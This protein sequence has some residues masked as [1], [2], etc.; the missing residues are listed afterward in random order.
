[1]RFHPQLLDALQQCVAASEDGNVRVYNLKASSSSNTNAN[2]SGGKT[3]LLEACLSGHL[4]SVTCCEYMCRRGSGS[5]GK[6]E[7]LYD[8]LISASRDKCLIV[9]SLVDFS[10]VRVITC[11]ESIES[12]FLVSHLFKSLPSGGDGGEQLDD[13]YVL[14]AGNEGLLKVWDTTTGRCVYNQ[15]ASESLKSNVRSRQG[16][17]GDS[18]ASA[19]QQHQKQQ[20]IKEA[21][22]AESELELFITHACYSASIKCLVLVTKDQLIYFFKLHESGVELVASSQGKCP[23]FV[24]VRSH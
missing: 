23:A 3:Q 18:L 11:Y 14:S 7:A 6:D 20:Q 12:L 21:A 24:V 13:R 19:Q 5:D 10:R 4:S 9:W 2:S 17:G 1:M 16:G 8:R 22:N 15:V